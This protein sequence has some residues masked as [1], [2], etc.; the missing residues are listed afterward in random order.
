MRII[1]NGA[2]GRMGTV[3]RT[4]IGEGCR[5]AVLAGAVDCCGQA[6]MYPS[7]WEVPGEADCIIDF[8]SHTGTGPLLRF[9]LERKLPVV[10]AATGQTGEERAAVEAASRR[11]PVFCS[12][13]LSLGIALLMQAVRQ[14]AALFPDADV[15]I[16]ERHHNQKLDTP[17]G[18]ALML[19]RAVQDVRPEAQ[20]LVGR[21]EDGPRSGRE[22][23]VHSLRLGNTVAAHEVIFG[24][25]HQTIT[26]KQEVLDRTL[27][28]DGALDAA[29]FLIRQPP[30][31]YDMDDLVG[32]REEE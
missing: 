29:A 7:L 6:G 32:N 15:E 8:S 27:F 30:G 31:L 11:I 12:G 23:G 9:A 10:L 26:L 14:T 13:N 28:A 20:L 16:V 19:A 4:R 3:L 5:G 18:T 24:T 25:K 17:S 2:A 1:V 21:Q 22:I